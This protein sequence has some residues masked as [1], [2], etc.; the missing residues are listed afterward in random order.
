M[1][2]V[3]PET[4]WVKRDGLDMQGRLLAFQ[5]FWRENAEMNKAPFEYNEAY[6]HIV[7]Q[8]FLQRVINGGGQIIREMALGKGALDLGVVFRSGK[9]PVEVKLLYN[10]RR[11]PEKAYAQALRYVEHLG[12]VEGWLVVF[13]PHFGDWDSKLRHED[14]VRDGKTLHVFFC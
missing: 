1:K 6:P 12:Q 13:D 14:V 11:S 8:A 3:V 9:Y 10:Y 2:R 5:E 7:L 4:P